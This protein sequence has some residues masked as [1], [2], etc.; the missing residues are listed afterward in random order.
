[1]AQITYEDALRD[2]ICEEMRNDPRIFIMGTD[3]EFMLWEGAAFREFGAERIRN[4]PISETGFVGAG[5]GAA[6]TGMRPIV[7]IGCSPFLYS[8]MDQIVNQAAKSRYMFGGQT[9]VPLVISIPVAYKFALAAH[10]SDRPWGLF[11]QAP[12]L[13]I[14]VPASPYD[15]KGLMKSAIRD[16]NPVLFF[17]DLTLCA[18]QGEVPEADFTVPIGVA[19]IKRAGSDV[20]VVAVAG[21]VEEALNAADQLAHDGILVEVVDVRTIVP[22]DRR[23]ILASVAKTG[24]LVV[25]DPAPGMC[26]VAAEVAATVAEDCF[27]YLKAPIIR[28]TA[29]DIPIPFSPDLENLIYPTAERIIAAVRRL[30]T[31]GTATFDKVAVARR[32]SAV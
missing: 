26:G 23:T 12:G 22:L 16:G 15:A 21:A 27:D 25:V 29:P 28:L 31:R 7:K 13:K 6:L 8:A 30:H 32:A 18:Q 5:V 20:T 11:A 1:M 4:T 24:R 10:H 9:S 2:A 17:E 19:D 3:L 14:V